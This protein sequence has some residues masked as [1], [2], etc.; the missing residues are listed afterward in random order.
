MVTKVGDNHNGYMG[1]INSINPGIISNNGA[2]K[3]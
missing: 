2:I 1:F 3:Q